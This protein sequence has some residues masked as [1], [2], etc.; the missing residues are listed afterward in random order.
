MSKPRNG[1]PDRLEE[2][3]AFLDAD[4]T[5]TRQDIAKEFGMSMRTVDRYR[6]RLRGHKNEVFVYPQEVVDQAGEMLDDGMSYAEVARTL[7]IKMPRTVARWYPGRGWT[8]AQV[9]EFATLASKNRGL[10]D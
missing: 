9:L 8:K 10:L 7:G 3:Q 5:H 2:V 1:R 4:H 6:A